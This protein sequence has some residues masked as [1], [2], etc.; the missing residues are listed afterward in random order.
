MSFSDSAL[1]KRRIE[2][3]RGEERRGEERQ[4]EKKECGENSREEVE[5]RSD[6]KHD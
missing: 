5:I 6:Y 1:G 3:R 4:R 2:E